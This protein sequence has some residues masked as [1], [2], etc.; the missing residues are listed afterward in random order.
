M[1]IHGFV[2]NTDVRWMY[3]DSILSIFFHL[4]LD[5][6][7]IKNAEYPT[8]FT[9]DINLNIVNNNDLEQLQETR[10]TLS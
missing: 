2:F 1:D 9:N 5:L 4:I 8:L 3:P 10:Y 7:S 6:Y